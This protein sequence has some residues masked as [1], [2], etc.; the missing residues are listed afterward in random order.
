MLPAL[1]LPRSSPKAFAASG[2]ALANTSAAPLGC[3]FQ[4][5]AAQNSVVS[6]HCARMR[7]KPFSGSG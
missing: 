7:D 4:A 2:G 6:A 3:R 5:I 1:I